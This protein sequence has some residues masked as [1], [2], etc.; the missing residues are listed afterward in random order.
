MIRQ[1]FVEVHIHTDPSKGED[2]FFQPLAIHFDIFPNVIPD[3][4]EDAFISETKR[5]VVESNPHRHYGNN[6]SVCIKICKPWGDE[7]TSRS[8]EPWPFLQNIASGSR[9]REFY[10]KKPFEQSCIL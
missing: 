3:T 1:T 9:R 7:K 4:R 10:N 6:H 5:E 8:P 2:S